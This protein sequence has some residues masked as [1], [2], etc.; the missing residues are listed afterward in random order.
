MKG[1]VRFDY[2]YW[3]VVIDDRQAFGPYGNRGAA[4]H[5]LRLW[6]RYER[7]AAQEGGR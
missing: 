2:P 3:W 7:Q 5:R 6:E 1:E 4:E